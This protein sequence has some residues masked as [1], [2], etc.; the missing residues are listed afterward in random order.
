MGDTVCIFEGHRRFF[1][2]S[3]W[4]GCVV[5]LT[6][7]WMGAGC[8]QSTNKLIQVRKVL[9][10][11]N[12]E[13]QK[14]FGTVNKDDLRELLLQTFEN[15]PHWQFNQDNSSAMVLRLTM[16]GVHRS[17]ARKRGKHLWI[18]TAE[19]HDR[20]G[21]GEKKFSG[22]A[23]VPYEDG[24]DIK[25]TFDAA[26]GQGLEQIYS[27][28]QAIHESNDSLVA[29]LQTPVGKQQEVSPA[30]KK[31]AIQVLGSRKSKEATGVLQQVLL[32]AEPALAQE[33]LSALTLLVTLPDS[34]PSFDYAERKP[35]PVRKKGDC[36][37]SDHGW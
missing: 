3:R 22:Y 15:K 9:I 35:A 34:M 16:D 14:S 10:D 13:F 4:L 25:D 8:S 2:L 11:L 1:N 12:P 20:S 26:L 21:A 28:A 6:L 29:W 37:G 36:G 18:L 31:M 27:A 5:A 17:A 7:V 24:D 33:A 23:A 30:K 32:G 19:L